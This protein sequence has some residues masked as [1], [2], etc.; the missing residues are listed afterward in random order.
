[1]RVYIGIDDTDSHR[2]GCTTY[3]GYILAKEVIKRWGRH[4]FLDFPGW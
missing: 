3:V 1:M 4:A 2:G